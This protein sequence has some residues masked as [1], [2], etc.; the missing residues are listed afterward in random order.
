[1]R[2]PA[3]L[4]LHAVGS[5]PEG[6]Y[7]VTEAATASPLAEVVQQRG[8]VPEEAALLAARIAEAVQA[9]H[10][11]GACHGR[12]SPDWVLLRG[13]L[14]P[15][16][17]PCGVPSQSEE[18]RRADVRALGEMLRGWLP[19][20][21]LRIRFGVLGPLYRLAENACQG[22]YARAD[23]LAADLRGGVEELRARWRQYWA[24]VILGCLLVVPLLLP[25]LASLLGAGEASDGR[26]ISLGYVLVSLIPAALVLG[27]MWARGLAWRWRRRRRLAA[28]SWRDGNTVGIVL[29]TAAFAIVVA[30]LLVAVAGLGTGITPWPGSLV[31]LLGELGATWLLGLCLAGVGTFAEELFRSLRGEPAAL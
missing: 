15:L 18:E 9:F 19:P 25:V 3:V 7:L 28:R 1:V 20:A 26:W 29:S 17:C 31:L 27:W 30:L 21:T 4:V 8:L 10:D 13:D 6:S 2:H 14:E 16:L 5:G 24:Q 11:Q 23:D 12:L 22:G